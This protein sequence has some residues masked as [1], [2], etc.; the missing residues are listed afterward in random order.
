MTELA[1]A[2]LIMTICLTNEVEKLPESQRSSLLQQLRTN[3]DADTVPLAA[4]ARI[5]LSN[6]YIQEDMKN[7]A[8][9]T[10]ERSVSEIVGAAAGIPSAQRASRRLETAIDRA[11]FPTDAG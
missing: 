11:F 5:F 1:S 10:A 8:L 3:T 7:L 9:G 2:A 4:I 6:L